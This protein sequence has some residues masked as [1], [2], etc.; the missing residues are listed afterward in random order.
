MKHAA[1]IFWLVVLLVGSVSYGSW[2]VWRQYGNNGASDSQASTSEWQP[3]VRATNLPAD[4]SQ[5]T[6]D[7]SLTDQNGREFHS[8]T[9]RGKVWVASIFYASCPGPCLKLNQALSGLQ[10]ESDFKDVKF[11]SITCDPQDDTPEVLKDYAARFNPDPKQWI[12]L[13]GD[14][15]KIAELGQSRF[16]LAVAEKSH[17]S[18]AVVLDKNSIVRGLF[19]LTDNNDVTQIRIRLRALL[20]E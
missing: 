1:L 4:G 8:R 19:D 11:V 6:P 18:E 17:S 3:T 9:L 2:L 13:T 16:M 15:K 10:S 20:R 5:P 7:F 12:F 14:L